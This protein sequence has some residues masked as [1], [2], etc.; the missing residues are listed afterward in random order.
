MGNFS[1][2]PM[3]AVARLT[4]VAEL[5]NHYAAACVH[6]NIPI[7]MVP[8]QRGRR[9]VGHSRMNFVGLVGHGLAAISV[10]GER[11]GARSLLAVVSI[12]G[13]LAVLGVLTAIL[14]LFMGFALPTWSVMA[15]VVTALLLMQGVSLSLVF[16]FLNLSARAGGHFIPAR[17]YVWFVD[18]IDTVWSG[19]DGL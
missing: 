14:H 18:R 5:W 10:F 19:N 7:S 11:I 12:A 4:V 16:T 13:V 9:L 17:D 2:L 3:R 15:V 6:A 1:L 8:T